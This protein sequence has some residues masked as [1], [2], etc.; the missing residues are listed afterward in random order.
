M[1]DHDRPEVFCLHPRQC[2]IG[3]CVSLVILLLDRSKTNQQMF[4]SRERRRVGILQENAERKNL[5]G[6]KAGRPPFHISSSLSAFSSRIHAALTSLS[7]SYS[8]SDFICLSLSHT[9]SHSDF[10]C[11]SLSNYELLVIACPGA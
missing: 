4:M 1:I 2:G 7:L 6:K 9:Y 3:H 5:E 10:T 8:H 11:L